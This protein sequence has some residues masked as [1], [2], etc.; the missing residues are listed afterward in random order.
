AKNL[1]EKLGI[2]LTAE[3]TE[4]K[5]TTMTLFFPILNFYNEKR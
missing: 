3:S 2:H 1:A 5:G 4:G